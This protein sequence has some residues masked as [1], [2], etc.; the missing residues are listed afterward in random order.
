[1]RRYQRRTLRSAERFGGSAGATYC[2]CHLSSSDEDFAC[3]AD[4]RVAVLF[5][6]P[7]QG[8]VEHSPDQ[9]PEPATVER[10]INRIARSEREI[11]NG[12][13]RA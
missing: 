2:T 5:W 7:R 3:F 6:H 11:E 12:L 1:M 4:K 10:I 9:L 13:R 8:N